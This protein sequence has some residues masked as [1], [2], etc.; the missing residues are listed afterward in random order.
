MYAKLQSLLRFHRQNVFNEHNGEAHYRA[1]IRLKRTKAYRE[2]CEANRQ[3][4][5]HR[6]SMR[7]L[8]MYA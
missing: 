6:R 3:A 2:M 7:F 1:L 5:D 8:S 4:A